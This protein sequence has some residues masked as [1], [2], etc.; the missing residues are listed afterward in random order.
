L[1]VDE[2][3]A[4]DGTLTDAHGGNRPSLL[5][6]R[7]A[8]ELL[9]KLLADHAAVHGPLPFATRS[10]GEALFALAELGSEVVA[11]QRCLEIGAG[12]GLFTHL[13]ASAGVIV[14]ALEPV[15][16]GFDHIRGTLAFVAARHPERV[17]LLDSQIEDLDAT[18]SYDLALSVNVFEHIDDWRV[19]I[20]RTVAALK[21]GGRAVILCPN[22]DVPYE[23]HFG[24]PIVLGKS[25]T[26]R[27][28]RATIA[29]YERE[30]DCAGLWRSLNF[31]SGTELRRFCREQGYS[32]SFDSTIVPRLFR[33][34]IDDQG[35]RSRRGALAYVLAAAE[36]CRVPRLW[37][38]LPLGLQPY[39]RVTI[40]R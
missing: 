30:Y 23:S 13:L 16:P 28:F 8:R 37:R 34:V 12:N 29:R 4:L 14:D 26:H 35:F 38:H 11:G 27:L 15:G 36:H 3:G 25:M 1:V 31:I 21:P 32:C 40:A 39:L 24:I 5:E 22:Y 9:A 19:A 20:R 33:R 6:A 17:R 10:T 18:G 7:Q 2:D